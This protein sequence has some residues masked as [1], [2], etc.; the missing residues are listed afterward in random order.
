MLRKAP[1]ANL[2]GIV[3]ILTVGWIP[4]SLV[5]NSTGPAKFKGKS[6][7]P[8]SPTAVSSSRTSTRW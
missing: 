5:Y 4:G 8:F 2:V 3:M 7:N 1:L 6:A